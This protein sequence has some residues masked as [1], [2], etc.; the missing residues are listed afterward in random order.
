MPIAGV[1]LMA[2]AGVQ[3]Q[4]ADTVSSAART[5]TVVPRVSISETFTDN[6]RLGSSNQQA[7][8]ITELKPGINI[9][10]N[11]PRLKGYFDFSLSQLAYAQG[12][13]S[14]RSQKSLST[15]ETLE[16]IDKWAFI[17]FNGAISQLTISAF[18]S[19]SVGNTG[20]NDNK[21][22]VSSYRVSPYIQ[23]TLG[24]FARYDARLSR[25]LTQSAAETGSGVASNAGTLKISGDS[26]FKALAWSTDVSRQSVDY[27][28]GRSTEDEQWNLGLT[29]SVTPQFS[30]SA[31]GGHESS[32][33][34]GAEK[35][36]N[37]TSGFGIS[38]VPSERTKLSASRNQRAF[39]EAHAV[40]FEH[41]TARTTWRYSD[42][43]DVSEAPGQL[44]LL[45][46]TLPITAPVVSGFITNALSLQR[47][48]DVSV[49]LQGVR[50]TVTL[51]ATQSESS[52]VDS[53]SSSVD[54]LSNSV[55]RQQ[56][57]SAN[58]THRLSP[59]SELGVLVAEQKTSGVSSLQ[60][61]NLKQLNLNLSAKV[62]KN[63]NATV[64]VRRVL[65]DSIA[66]P[67][68]ETAITITLTVQ[69]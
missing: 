3:A 48:Q 26:A 66:A 32:N 57:F 2:T 1:V 24:S 40:S 37:G 46:N 4:L 10:N 38:W 64:G 59:D 65:F 50:D 33:F 22:Q 15:S 14:N 13:S 43:K 23:G 52:R 17:D 68:G 44:S 34:T 21:T 69:F 41:R 31:N 5:W 60:E 56:G 18:G 47:R 63:A 25:T 42:T 51:T 20:V 16:A 11:A 8:Q 67:Y 30:V 53:V 36:G 6:V 49:S 58:Y 29:Y 35:Q 28:A 55:V 61:S 27:S 45:A 54:D 9:Q 12:S 62:G 39:G 19:Q 7:E